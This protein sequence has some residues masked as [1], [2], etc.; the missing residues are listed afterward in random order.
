MLSTLE[1]RFNEKLRVEKMEE[2]LVELQK[3]NKNLKTVIAKQKK[4]L[5]KLHKKCKK[6]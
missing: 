6:Q 1:I 4:E 5:K 3:E 2:D